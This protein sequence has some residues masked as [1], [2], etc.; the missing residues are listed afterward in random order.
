MS[1]D[2]VCTVN[3][4]SSLRVDEWRDHH[5]RVGMLFPDGSPCAPSMTSTIDLRLST[6]SVPSVHHRHVSPPF[7][8]P[9]EQV[10]LCGQEPHT[11][12][13]ALHCITLRSPNIPDASRLRRMSGSPVQISRPSADRIGQRLLNCLRLTRTPWQPGS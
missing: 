11:L 7:S 8:G 2:C 9:G 6:C 4:A 12:A 5:R 13:R 1:S 3:C 10:G